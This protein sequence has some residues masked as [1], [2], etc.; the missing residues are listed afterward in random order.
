VL[1]SLLDAAMITS[2]AAITFH[3]L[4]A[5]GN[6]LLTSAGVSEPV[7]QNR[8]GHGRRNVTQHYTHVYDPDLA[9]AAKVMGGPLAPCLK[10]RKWAKSGAKVLRKTKVA[11]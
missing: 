7:R 5:V 10:D 11:A 2:E 1:P 3:T 9:A 4:R 8:L 6:S